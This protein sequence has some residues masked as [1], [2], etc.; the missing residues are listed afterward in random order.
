MWLELKGKGD[1]VLHDALF[2]DGHGPIVYILQGPAA[3]IKTGFLQ[4]VPAVD[5][6]VE[7]GVVRKTVQLAVV[8]HGIQVA[9]INYFFI[10]LNTRQS[11]NVPQPSGFHPGGEISVPHIEAIQ[12]RFGYKQGRQF[13][14][15][16][17]SHRFIVYLDIRILFFKQVDILANEIG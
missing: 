7:V 4:D 12:R 14:V 13:V 9:G 2:L 1:G 5:P 11:L 10:L 8:G 16:V 17:P 3:V 15:V 6:D